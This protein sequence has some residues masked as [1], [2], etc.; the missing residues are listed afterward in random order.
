VCCFLQQGSRPPATNYVDEPVQIQHGVAQIDAATADD[1]PSVNGLQYLSEAELLN[2]LFGDGSIA[3]S[4]VLFVHGLSSQFKR[5]LEQG[6][7]IQQRLQKK[8][9]V[10]SWP[11]G[12]QK[13]HYRQE[14]SR[15]MSRSLKS[16]IIQITT[17]RF[18]PQDLQH[19]P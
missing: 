7:R 11:S 18:L 2:S 19:L 15:V 10:I 3:Q 9:L 13:H 6:F 17:D 8:V 14:K 16:I 5:S 12:S 4:L 1:H